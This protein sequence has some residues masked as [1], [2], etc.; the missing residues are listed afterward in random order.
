MTQ[1]LLP[2]TNA[3]CAGEYQL[4]DENDQPLNHTTVAYK[5]QPLPYVRWGN[6]W[7]LVRVI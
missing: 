3:P 6:R 7:V 2:G 1:L 5:G 4:V